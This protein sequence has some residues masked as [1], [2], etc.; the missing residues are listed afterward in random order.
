MPFYKLLLHDP[1][2]QTQLHRNILSSLHGYISQLRTASIL[3]LTIS[4]GD[5]QLGLRVVA[6]RGENWLEL[7][8]LHDITLDLQLAAHEESLCV[9]LAGNELAKVL[10]RKGEGDYVDELTLCAQ[11]QRAPPS[12]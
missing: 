4:F 2:S 3:S 9:G 12:R 11:I 6:G 1:S 7:G 8:G 10:L 5:L